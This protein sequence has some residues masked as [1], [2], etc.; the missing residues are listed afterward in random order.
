MKVA[1][2]CIFFAKVKIICVKTDMCAEKVV[3]I[4]HIV[5]LRGTKVECVHKNSHL[6]NTK[7]SSNIK[8]KCE[9]LTNF[10]NLRLS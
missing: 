4:W 10:N 9:L 1:E 6:D 3:I 2:K 8:S 7:N 5:Y